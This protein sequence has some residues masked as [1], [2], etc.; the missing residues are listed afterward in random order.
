MNPRKI[1][2]VDDS[3][4]A[5]R[6][7][8]QMLG[9]Q[10]YL[11]EE[12]SD[13]AQALERYFLGRHDIVL[14]DMVMT[15]MYGLEVLAKLREFDPQVRVIVATA[16]IQKSTEEQARAAGASAFINKPLNRTKL[17]ETVAAVI[18]GTFQWN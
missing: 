16:D 1:L 10:G 5:R 7:A 4:L 6:S 18:E 14:L 15:G 11:V 13:G 9:E 3:S 17:Q 8:R 2:L 12:A